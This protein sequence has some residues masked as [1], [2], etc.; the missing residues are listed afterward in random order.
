MRGITTCLGIA[1]VGVLCLSS[2]S[3]A[4][5]GSTLEFT[6]IGQGFSSDDPDVAPTSGSQS[7]TSSSAR[8]TLGSTFGRL[9]G[10]LT[11]EGWMGDGLLQDEAGSELL[12][13]MVPVNGDQAFRSVR[14]VTEGYL[15]YEF[16]DSMLISAGLADMSRLFDGARGA[17]DPRSQF[18]NAS[19]RIS[20]ATEL[21]GGLG[22]HTLAAWFTLID[23]KPRSGELGFG[24][25]AGWAQMDLDNTDPYYF[26]ELRFSL[27]P[28]L[29]AGVYGWMA[30]YP[31]TRWMSAA[32]KDLSLGVGISL[33]FEPTATS[34]TVW[35]LR[36]ALA[37]QHVQPNRF[38]WTWSAG[39]EMA[40]SLWRR[41]QDTCGVA[42]GM[43]LLSEDYAAFRV[44]GGD[45]A[46]DEA[47]FEVYYRIVLLKRD[48]RRPSI[49]L[50]PSLQSITGANGTDSSVSVWGVRL[51]SLYRF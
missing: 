22:P 30:D 48:F 25:T 20:A 42:F 34:E 35:F 44:S 19:F 31:H 6:G 11:V 38:R 4:E 40:G 49:E 45:E 37:D 12:T 43:N 39:F 14:A 8:L 26:T 18:L 21:P 46:E 9:S 16:G 33:D 23:S 36:S 29:V 17:S 47:V 5:V 27:G 10:I 1:V 13:T 7:G 28:K 2:G 50:T 51:S 24:M 41:P 15:S 32:T 3:S